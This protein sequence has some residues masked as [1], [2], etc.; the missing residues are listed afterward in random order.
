LVEILSQEEIEALLSTLAA[1]GG[2]VETQEVEVA[3]GPASSAPA[4]PL[5]SAPGPKWD[6]KRPIAY[7]VYDFRRPDK[8]SKEQL[9]TLQ[10]VHETFSRLFA[11]SLSAYLRVPSHVDLVSVEQVPYE[12]YHHSLTA[13]I[14]SVFTM[15]P[16]NG[17]AILEMEFNVV[18]SMIDRLL[19]GPG[20]MVKSNMA[21]TE[22]E[23]ALTESILQR[24]LNDLKL[25]WEGIAQFT[26]RRELIETQAQFVQIVP[27][28]DVVVSILFEV[29]IG[30]LR[31]AMSLCIP[32]VLLKPISSKLSGQ[33]WFAASVKKTDGQNAR[34]LA[35]R[36]ENTWV[37][38]VCRLGTARIHVQDLL[39]LK[40]GDTIRLDRKATD[41]IDL[42]ICNKVKFRGKPGIAG[43]R[44][45]VHINRIVAEDPLTV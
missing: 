16:L 24:A 34:L 21:L 38:C 22:I 15:P 32:Y 35:R 13:S 43:R 17:Q 9:R 12:E 29:K 45:A 5:M 11:S 31:G 30:E 14:I 10:M 44:V 39:D 4:P 33:R 26:P 6:E 42:M 1:D 18:F 40:V 41:E 28:N 2:G 8:F 19:G 27:P 23:K 25:A 3:P 36:L 20:N 37:T 7:E